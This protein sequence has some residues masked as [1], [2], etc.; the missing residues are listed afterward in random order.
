MFRSYEKTSLIKK[1]IL[2]PKPRK[3]KQKSAGSASEGQL[4]LGPKLRLHSPVPGAFYLPFF[5]GFL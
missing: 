4:L 5:Q 1:Y 3:P 2:N